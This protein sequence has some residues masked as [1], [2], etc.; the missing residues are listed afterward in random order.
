[1]PTPAK[2]PRRRSAANVPHSWEL[3]TWGTIAPDVWP[4]TTE[5]GKWITRAY[6]K[7]LK[8]ADAL[9]R[10]GYKIVILG[11][12]YTRWLESRA[13]AV[14]EFKSNNPDIGK[15]REPVAVRRRRKA[16]ALEGA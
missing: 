5:R 7:E 15:P 6:R 16:K 10:V 12:P 4:H 13:T 3:D 11:V 9:S 14:G 8:A 2:T 1:M